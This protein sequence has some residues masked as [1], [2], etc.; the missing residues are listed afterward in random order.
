MKHLWK[1]VTIVFLASLPLMASDSTWYISNELMQSIQES[2]EFTALSMPWALEIISDSEGEI[3]YKD[4]TVYARRIDLSTE[5]SREVTITYQ[6]GRYTKNIYTDGLLSAVVQGAGDESSRMEFSY[7]EGQLTERKNIV[8]GTLEQLITY[9]RHEDGTLGGTRLID[10]EGKSMLT[11]F[12]TD[13]TLLTLSRQGGSEVRITEILSGNL[14]AQASLRDGV[15]IETYTAAYDDEGTLTLEEIILGNKLVRVF[16][17]E[18]LL[19]SRVEEKDQDIRSTTR[20]EY[21]SD[22]TLIRS[23]ELN[24][25]GQ[26]ERIERWYVNA[27]L[28]TETQWLDGVP[29]RSTRYNGDGT[30]VVT[31]F[32]EGLPYADVNYA[33]DGKRIISIEYRKEQ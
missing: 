18:G 27:A 32:E 1:A 12:N 20:Y 8:Q 17:P 14:M 2:D 7:T 24:E 16:S 15:P 11:L 30:M 5:D 6:D 21:D 13:G 26:K 31:I 28:K 33:S 19:L 4:G 22:G 9:Y 25:N 23:D 29:Q 3:L 10:R